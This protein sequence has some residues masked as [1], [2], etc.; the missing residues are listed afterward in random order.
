[1]QSVVCIRIEIDLGH[2]DIKRVA[3]PS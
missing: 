1:M 2:I 3:L